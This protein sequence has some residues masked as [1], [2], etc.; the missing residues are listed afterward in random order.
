VLSLFEEYTGVSGLNIS[1]KKTTPLCI[2][3]LA[4]L[5]KL[6]Q[7]LGLKTKGN[8]KHPGLYVEKTIDSIAEVTVT[9]IE[10]SIE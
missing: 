8:V 9:K 10:I 2:S 7:R 6:L 5:W 3:T 1:V 4:P